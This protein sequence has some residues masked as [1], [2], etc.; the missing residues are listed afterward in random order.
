M[1]EREKD[2]PEQKD[3]PVEPSGLGAMP[4]D[5]MK[6]FFAR[7]FTRRDDR[8]FMPGLVVGDEERAARGALVAASLTEDS[9]LDATSQRIWNTLDEKTRHG[10]LVDFRCTDCFLM[11][12]QGISKADMEAMS[13]EALDAAMEAAVL[14]Q[15]APAGSPRTAPR[16]KLTQLEDILISFA[17]SDA[18]TEMGKGSV[19]QI[20]G[21][22]ERC[23]GEITRTLAGEGMRMFNALGRLLEMTERDRPRKVGRN[24]PCPCGSG[25]KHK[26]CCGGIGAE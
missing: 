18:P 10:A 20:S 21:I 15:R 19:L 1:E 17:P 26:K 7:G 9:F 23:G 12:T 5:E 2:V 4:S 6:A 8:M 13:R 22:C 25:K 24:D 11:D 3:S 16:E 14:A